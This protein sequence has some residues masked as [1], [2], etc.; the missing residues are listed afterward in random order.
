VPIATA[1]TTQE[2][3]TWSLLIGVMTWLPAELDAFAER[4]AGLSH[5][6][7]WVLRWLVTDADADVHM[8]RLATGASVTPSHLSR[9]VGRLERRGLL[10][11]QPDPH[12]ARRTQVQLTDAGRS[13]VE[14]LEPR[15]AAEIR[16]RVFDLLGD[17]QDAQLEDLSE[18]ILE[19]MR[20]DCIALVPPRTT[21]RLP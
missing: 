7:Y 4:E 9:I 16:G 13:L 14:D 2:D 19:A 21:P 18:R 1:L 17:R 6:E 3:R 11:R 15:Y 12:D 8:T 10:A 5:A 20:P